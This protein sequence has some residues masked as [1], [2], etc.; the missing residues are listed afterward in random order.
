MILGTGGNTG[1]QAATTVT[2]APALDD[3]RPR[4]A[5]RVMFRE[6]RV[7]MALGGCIGLLG[8]V[9]AG[10]VFSWPVRLVIGAT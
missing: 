2:R 1:T 6:L 5:P 10:F 7:G 9:V 8:L 4:H 3:V